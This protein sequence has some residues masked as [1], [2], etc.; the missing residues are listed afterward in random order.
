MIVDEQDV[1]DSLAC[2]WIALKFEEIEVMH[3][4][5]M[6][7]LCNLPLTHR[8]MVLREADVL[9]RVDWSIP[10][11]TRLHRIHERVIFMTRR[12]RLWLIAIQRSGLIGKYDEQR[13]GAALNMLNVFTSS[14]LREVYSHSSRFLRNKLYTAPLQICMKR[15]RDDR[16]T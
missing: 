10:V 7:K 4:D 14:E 3:I 6:C 12:T 16:S 15:N 9:E 13:L 1:V 5:D 2:W 8:T 11:N